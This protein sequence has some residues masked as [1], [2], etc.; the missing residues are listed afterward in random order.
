[1]DMFGTDFN[2]GAPRNVVAAGEA[3]AVAAP[4]AQNYVGIPDS[5]LRENG[6]YDITKIATHVHV[7]WNNEDGA[8][9]A[10]EGFQ[11]GW[12]ENVRKAIGKYGDHDNEI[13]V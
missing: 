9:L 7:V 8:L 11:M 12:G 10:R 5:E 6:G 2:P 3:A 4:A 1:M 13:C